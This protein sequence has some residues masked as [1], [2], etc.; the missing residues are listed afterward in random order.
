[1]VAAGIGG[2]IAVD[3]MESAEMIELGD[4]I[5][6][7]GRME[8]MSEMATKSMIRRSSVQSRDDEHLASV[9]TKRRLQL[10]KRWVQ[11]GKLS[12]QPLPCLREC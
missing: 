9:R 12:I 5:G 4:W 11:R 10:Q 6:T 3:T 1:M 2:M 7:D 8:R